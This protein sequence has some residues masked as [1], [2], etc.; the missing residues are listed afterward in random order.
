MKTELRTVKDSNE[1]MTE[2]IEYLEGQARPIREVERD[3]D[4][5]FDELQKER[6]LRKKAEAN[7]ERERMQVVGSSLPYF[8]LDPSQAQVFPL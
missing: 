4:R 7:I 2:E 3:R 5:A 1:S 6:R 8:S